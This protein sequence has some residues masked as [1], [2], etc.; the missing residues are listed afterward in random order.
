MEREIERQEARKGEVEALLAD[1]SGLAGGRRE[2][3]ALSEEFTSL[4]ARLDALLARWEEL[5]ARR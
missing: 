3:Q 5:E 1:A 2:L 4:E